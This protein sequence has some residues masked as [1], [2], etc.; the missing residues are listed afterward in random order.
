A[1]A[2]ALDAGVRRALAAYKKRFYPDAPDTALVFVDA[3]G[4]PLAAYD[5]AGEFRADLD[6]AGVRRAELHKSTAERMAFRVHDLRGT[7]VTLNLAAGKSESWISDRTGHKS[8]QMIALYKR[9]ART[10]RTASEL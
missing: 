3:Q 6:T 10:A 2:W 8:S 7:F 5:G 9:T 4:R 1:R